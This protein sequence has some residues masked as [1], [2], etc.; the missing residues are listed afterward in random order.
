MNNFNISAVCAFD[1]VLAF[2]RI[3]IGID[4]PNLSGPVKRLRRECR[5]GM[6]IMLGHQ[7]FNPVWKCQLDLL[8]PSTEALDALIDCLGHNTASQVCYAELALDI[9]V[10]TRGAAR[11]LQRQLA[12]RLVMLNQRDLVHVE[13]GTIYYSRR[14]GES[15]GKR[16]RVGVM[17]SDRRSKLAS[18]FAGQPCVH[19]EI[20][21]SGKAALASIGLASVSDLVGFD[22]RRF[23]SGAAALLE[24]P[25]TKKDLGLLLG[26]A[27]V[28]DSALRKRA[29]KFRDSCS[30][31][32]Q[33]FMHNAVR[34]HDGLFR[35]L[36]R[37]PLSEVMP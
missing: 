8:Q 23:W 11:A 25:S 16:G 27:D 12:E 5:G 28:S 9:I 10:R 21:L 3:R 7:R 24:L 13:Q 14:T 32:K 26:P 18:D 34:L 29:D 17:Y 6:K 36:A 31:G 15:G 30:V 19:I 35:A 22:H 37:T 1:R 20:R 2:D 4:S 33:F